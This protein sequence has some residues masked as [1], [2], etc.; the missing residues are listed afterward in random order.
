MD[1]NLGEGITGLEATQKG[2]TLKTCN[3]IP[4]IAD[5]AFVKE[6]VKV[7]YLR[8]GCTHYLTKQF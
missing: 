1:I 3:D 4:I 8:Y 5:T 7:N 2:K 6:K